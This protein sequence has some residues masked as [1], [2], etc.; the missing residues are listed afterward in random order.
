[1]TAA[2]GLSGSFRSRVRS[3]SIGHSTYTGRRIIFHSKTTPI[4]GPVQKYDLNYSYPRSHFSWW[5]QAVDKK[6]IFRLSQK[7]SYSTKIIDPVIN[8]FSPNE[9]IINLHVCYHSIVKFG[10]RGSCLGF[11]NTSHV[12]NLDRFRK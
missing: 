2:Y 3:K 6:I 5:L 11:S 4:R 7:V 10:V 1:M 8:G 9:L 12:D